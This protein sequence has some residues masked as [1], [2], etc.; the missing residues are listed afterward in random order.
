MGHN[1]LAGTGIC[2]LALG[3]ATAGAA[4]LA[5]PGIVTKS[6]PLAAVSWTGCYV[7]VHIG[8]G[9]G[10]TDFASQPTTLPA[11]TQT[12]TQTQT[13]TDTQ[14]QV[15][16]VRDKDEDR[17]HRDRDKNHDHDK[18]HD[19]NHD[20]D[21]ERDK[22]HG[23]RNADNDHSHDR[24]LDANHDRDRLAD[25]D[26]NGDRQSNGD[27]DRDLHTDK[28]KDQDRGR[29]ADGDHHRGKGGDNDADQDNDAE[30]GRQTDKD[31]HRNR[32]QDRHHGAHADK[33][34]D[35]DK[36]KTI[37]TTTTT[38]VVTTTTQ[39]VAGGVIGSAFSDQSDGI[40]G[41]GQVGCNYQFNP[42]WVV[43]VEGDFSAAG[44]S[45]DTEGP[46]LIGQA[47]SA[48]QAETK[49]IASLTGR[50]GYAFDRFL[51]FVRGG[52]AWAH[53]RYDSR[54]FA[55]MPFDFTGSDTR[56][57]WTVGAGVEWAF[58]GNWSAKVEYDYYDFGAT[59][60]SLNGPLG[61]IPGNITQRI[62]AVTIAL[63][64]HF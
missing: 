7:G 11:R 16:K 51:F 31:H 29:L 43:G 22:D 37:T 26:G 3:G 60:V 52:G 6:P 35:R 1:V 20:H 64:Y 30:H 46:F 23:H 27:D 33:D 42:Q 24:H 32:D 59:S 18:Q 34:Q 44:I 15:I 63:N 48:L 2:L 21:K 62:Q 55:G 38:T 36:Q 53:Q 17:D 49:W 13:T 57:G 40:L 45:G 47:F 14:T 61:M 39:T 58:L 5:A 25:K 28:D 41:G 50:V 56:S 9:W 8:G 10:T 12:M 19:K 4:D 54:G